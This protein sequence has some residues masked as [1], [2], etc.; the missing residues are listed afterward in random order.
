MNATVKKSQDVFWDPAM[1]TPPQ[2]NSSLLR[3]GMSLFKKFTYSALWPGYEF[4]SLLGFYYYFLSASPYFW[5]GLI[6]TF[7]PALF[8]RY[9]AKAY[10]ASFYPSDIDIQSNL[11]IGHT[12]M[13]Q[14]RRTSFRQ[15]FEMDQNQN[16]NPWDPNA[17]STAPSAVMSGQSEMRREL[18]SFRSTVI[19]EFAN[20][21]G[22]VQ[23]VEA[24]SLE[25]HQTT[26][27]HSEEL[28]RALKAESAALRTQ[29][30]SNSTALTFSGRIPPPP[31]PPVFLYEDG[32][33][34]RVNK[35]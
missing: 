14:R 22:R 15:Q 4:K 33:E 5:F 31:P 27:A 20:Y 34:E 23:Q 30:S 3:V 7:F 19:T 26:K 28:S 35:Y 6:I 9:L 29:I 8:P 21:E 17:G 11:G 16:Q 2:K 32:T 13:K 25:L 10:K 24:Q 1:Q 12:K 18:Q